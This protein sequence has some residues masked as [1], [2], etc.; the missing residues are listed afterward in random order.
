MARRG[1]RREF[2]EGSVARF[3]VLVGVLAVLAA[4]GGGA[5]KVEKVKKC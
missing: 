2:G 5:E 3:G 4:C 1:L